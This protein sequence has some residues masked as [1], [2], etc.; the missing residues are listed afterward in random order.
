MKKTRKIVER[1]QRD[2]YCNR[3]TKKICKN[4]NTDAELK[5]KKSGVLV[6]KDD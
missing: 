2:Y 5:A 3:Y 4:D 6:N 1:Y